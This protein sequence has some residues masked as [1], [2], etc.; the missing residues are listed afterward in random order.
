MPCAGA[1]LFFLCFFACLLVAAPVVMLLLLVLAPGMP[2]PGD[3]DIS[4]D[5][6]ALGAFGT[7]VSP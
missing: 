5:D 2:A 4:F 3:L 6:P 7:I 1:L